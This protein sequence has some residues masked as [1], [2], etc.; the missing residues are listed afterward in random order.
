MP[1]R[2]ADT[3]SE[4]LLPAPAE[5]SSEEHHPT[6][7]LGNMGVTLST[8]RII[9]PLSFVISVDFA[10]QVYGMSSTPNMKDIHDRYPCAFSPQPFA[11]AGFFGPQQ[12]LQIIWLRELF[13]QPN[14]VEKSALRYAPWYALGNGC[15]ALWMFLWTGDRM[16][17]ANVPV[18]INT[19]TQ[20][21]YMLFL[22]DPSPRS[23]QSMLTNAVNITFTGI[24]VLDIFHNTTAAYFPH[25]APNLLTQI[26]T[27]VAA[28]LSA[29]STPLLFGACI[30][31]D[32]F[33]VAVGQHQ[34]AQ[35]ALGAYGGGGGEGWARLLGGLGLGVAGIVGFR[36]INGARWL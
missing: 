14:Q 36:A 5:Y 6:A 33:G 8:A 35:K 17:A 13:R 25:I 29:L 18:V 27:V 28:P 10:C 21:Y 30:A 20:L 31:Y 11:I 3:S 7:P 4:P 19:L 12:I 22:R 32:L 1:P 23:Y 2:S 34:L 26:A 24:G 15:I 16:K 9:A